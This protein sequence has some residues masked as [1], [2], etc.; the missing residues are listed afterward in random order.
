MTCPAFRRE[1]EQFDV[2]IFQESH[3]LEGGLQYVRGVDGFDMLSEERRYKSLFK[4]QYGG[5]VVLAR[6]CLKLRRNEEWTSTDVLTLESDDLVL[7]SAYIVPDSNKKWEKFADVHP[8]E[9]LEEVMTVLG[10]DRRM[11][12]TAGDLNARTA[13]RG[14]QESY[15]RTSR[16]TTT[17]TR[18]TQLLKLCREED[19]AILNGGA[20][21]DSSSG[22]FTSHRH[23]GEAVVDYFIGNRRAAERT[24]GM[25]VR[26][27]VGGSSD[28]SEVLLVLSWMGNSGAEGNMSASKK[29]KRA[30]K[31]VRGGDDELEE[32]MDE[33]I[34]SVGTHITR[35]RKLYGPVR[36]Q[37][38]AAQVYVDGSCLDNG[39]TEAR[40]GS[41][42]F[43]GPGN[44]RNMAVRVPGA[45]SNNRGEAYAVLQ[46]VLVTDVHKTLVIFS[47]SELTIRTLTYWAPNRAAT[48][49]TA[50]HGDI[51]ADI[52]WVISMRPAPV[53]FRKV[54]AHSGNVHNDGADELAKLGAT[55][56]D[57]PPY[58][59]INRASMS[60]EWCRCAACEEGSPVIMDDKVTTD[61]PPAKNEKDEGVLSGAAHDYSALTA[62]SQECRDLQLEAR[63]EILG[64]KTCRHF[65]RGVDRLRN[66]Q[67]LRALH[68][69]S[70]ALASVFQ[71]RMNM[72]VPPPSSF[73]LPRRLLNGALVD[74]M[75]DATEDRTDN[76]I[77]T[78]PFTLEEVA[79]AK[80]RLKNR[81]DSAVGGD[82]IG[83]D[84]ILDMD[85]EA[86][87][88][89]CN[90]CVE[91][92]GAP[93]S[94]VRTVL[95]GLCKRGKP[96]E[97]PNS[98]RTIALESCVV[99]FMTQLITA[100]LVLFAEL[101]DLLPPSQNGF[102]E[103]YRTSNN[104]FILDTARRK[105]RAGGTPLYV[106]YV[107]MTNAFPS[108]DHS[109][110]WLK[111]QRWGAGGPI[112]D[113]LR[114]LYSEMSYVVSHGGEE[115]TAFKANMG[116]LIGDT[117]S[118]ILWALYM[119]DLHQH[120]T[121]DEG[122]VQI[123]NVKVG[124]LE[125]ADDILLLSTTPEGLQLRLN[126]VAKWC[127]VN[128]LEVNETKSVV[129][130]FG[131]AVT[132][133][134][135]F[136]IGGV[137][138]RVVAQETYIGFTVSSSGSH[139]LRQHYGAKAAKARAAAYQI[140]SFEQRLGDI[141]PETAL[142]LYRMVVDPHLVHGCEVSLDVVDRA[143]EELEEIL[144]AFLR[145][146]LGLTKR[147]IIASLFTETGVVE[148]GYRRLLIA[149]DF[150]IYMAKCPEDMWVRQALW[151][152]LSLEFEGEESW[153]TDL[154]KVIRKLPFSCQC[155]VLEEWLVVDTVEDL[156]KVIER[157][158][159]AELQ[160]KVDSSTKLYLIQGRF[161]TDP[162]TGKRTTVPRAFRG[163]LRL[164]NP[165]HRKALVRVILS[166]HNMALE[167][168]RYAT[169]KVDR[170]ERVC[171][172]GCGK[173][174]SP[175][176]IWLECRGSP[177]LVDGRRLLHAALPEVC[178]GEELAQIVDLD[179][180]ATEQLKALLSLPHCLPILGL[181]AYN[182]DKILEQKPLD[183]R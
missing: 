12:L 94:W 101:K 125:Q 11:V 2:N 164:T 10:R 157:G 64:A 96:P 149:L 48:G 16:D 81:K 52:I 103:G 83:Y 13:S 82:G 134:P 60:R 104:M 58:I 144:V 56:P 47:D 78:S 70:D 71:G 69:V 161:T 130:A 113:W 105:A 84:A 95:V 25:R 91:K 97:D 53:I 109:T 7:I 118:P 22:D 171:R 51:F 107:D 26:K 21:F 132:S 173:V 80:V 24:L 170:H 9:R 174:E 128:F 119:A 145:R 85:N 17:N 6:K 46:A 167:I 137:P 34:Q 142:Y 166:N 28:H 36:I 77:F 27:G 122:K 74:V 3:L 127:S 57:V 41:G 68:F 131:R 163:Y 49:W 182:V 32:L 54:K 90:R 138:I 73:N 18:G 102:R 120:M 151:E 15:V 66:P 79:A 112:F 179:G 100:R 129:M 139:M 178:T 8:Y 98:Y 72:A 180:D 62:R 126:A 175:E 136:T 4:Y 123:G 133:L 31:R 158:M 156:K 155:P 75:G 99:K 143:L 150:L 177:E 172:Y 29:R 86:I 14:G 55:L 63:K 44:R 93:G 124:C 19:Y 33:A 141:P 165:D 37:G 50:T 76:G 159:D 43:F 35:L 30:S 42:I 38:D 111:L 162:R 117:C 169:P 5:V 106:A 108:T 110:L 148:L 45:Q 176:H 147:S 181:Y 116:I 153:I 115:S 59:G 160:R 23:Q 183:W 40:A 135:P 61:L 20:R 39:G 146:L 140:W 67:P 154:Q 92:K 114:W 89:L 65:W 1:I 168:W 121:E 152:S 87:L 88:R